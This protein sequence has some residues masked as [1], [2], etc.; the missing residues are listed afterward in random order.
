M[1]GLR[2][3][4]NER[5][6]SV[7]VVLGSIA[8]VAILV[9][10][11]G[12]H[13]RSPA[14]FVWVK[15]DATNTGFTGSLNSP[16]T[17]AVVVSTNGTTL[18]NYDMSN[19]DIFVMADNVTITN[20]RIAGT[21]YVGKHNGTDKTVTGTKIN[22]CTFLG[23][24]RL[25]GIEGINGVNDDFSY[26]DMSGYE[27]CIT[28][29]GS[30]INETNFSLTHNYCHGE[31]SNNASPHYDGFEI[32]GMASGGLVQG[33]NIILTVDPSAAPINMT[34]SGHFDGTITVDHN[35]AQSANCG[36][37]I[38]GDDSQGTTAIHA[39]VTNNRLTTDTPSTFC[40]PPAKASYFTLETH[41]AS[42]YTVTGNVDDNTSTAIC[43]GGYRDGSGVHSGC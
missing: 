25:G 33:N 9:G 26:N 41:Q 17:S 8:S 14:G 28:E 30:S 39:I 3:K 21:I 10:A 36:Y 5:G 32:Y 2:H 20:C 7:G 35:W 22:H 13:W 38:L 18:T 12:A 43:A 29:W 24:G 15:P 19:A 40:G 31:Q 27:N 4:R 6:A 34:P 16:T 23:S 1:M 42:T 11:V 37:V